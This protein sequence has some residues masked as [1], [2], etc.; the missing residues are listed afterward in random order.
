[1]FVMGHTVDYIIVS[2]TCDFHFS[3]EV[4]FNLFYLSK[5]F[6]GIRCLANKELNE[7]GKDEG[8]HWFLHRLSYMDI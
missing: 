8:Q 3:R 5:Y 2:F 1:Q 7:Q 6:G 4:V